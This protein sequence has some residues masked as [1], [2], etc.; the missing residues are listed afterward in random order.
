MDHTVPGVIISF[1]AVVGGGLLLLGRS[2]KNKVQQAFVTLRGL[3]AAKA[4]A[5]AVGATGS[6]DAGVQTPK[7]LLPTCWKRIVRPGVQVLAGYPLWR[8]QLYET[9][10]HLQNEKKIVGAVA[11]D[12]MKA[13]ANEK[14][15]ALLAGRSYSALR[16]LRDG[17]WT[18]VGLSDKDRPLSELLPSPRAPEDDQWPRDAEETAPRVL[19]FENVDALFGLLGTTRFAS[20]A[21]AAHPGPG[22]Y[23]SGYRLRVEELLSLDRAVKDLATDSRESKAYSVVLLVEDKHLRKHL[24]RWMEPP[25]GRHRRDVY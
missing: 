21:S 22:S 6:S 25:L 18:A 23:V 13:A 17:L 5:K 7:M 10:C 14:A 2:Q 20:K 8:S 15:N 9:L 16:A 3:P 1:S 12:C 19:V 24:L 4:S 11:V